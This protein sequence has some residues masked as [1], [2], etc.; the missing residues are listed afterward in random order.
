MITVDGEEIEINKRSVSY[1]GTHMGRFQKLDLYGGAEFNHVVQGTARD[2]L[3][4]A[5][6]TVEAA[7]YPLVLTVHDELLSEVEAGFGSADEYESLM[8][9]PREWFAGLPLVTKAWEDVRY[10]K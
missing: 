1:W 9:Q 2:V 4:E 6:F 7:G 8:S 10:V 5:A 3:V